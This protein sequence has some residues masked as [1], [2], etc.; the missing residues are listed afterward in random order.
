MDDQINEQ[1]NSQECNCCDKNIAKE[2]QKFWY[3]TSLFLNRRIVNFA[4]IEL[5]QLAC[6]KRELFP[7]NKWFQKKT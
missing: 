4:D 1:F 6:I 3:A 7:I 2:G 5:A